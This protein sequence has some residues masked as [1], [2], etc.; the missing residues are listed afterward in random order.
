[1]R[2]ATKI[3]LDSEE[4]QQ[5]K[6]LVRSGKTPARLTERARIVLLA[7]AG[8][9]NVHIG[10]TLGISRQKAGRWRERYAQKRFAGIEQDAPRPGRHPQISQMQRSAVVK[11]VLFALSID[12]RPQFRDSSGNL[13]DSGEFGAVDIGIQCLLEDFSIGRC[14]RTARGNKLRDLLA[15]RIFECCVHNEISEG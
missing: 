11:S 4:E 8:Q 2:V 12:F 5:L 3:E 6:R 9:E 10:A 15:P 13:W 14:G 7:A 1:M